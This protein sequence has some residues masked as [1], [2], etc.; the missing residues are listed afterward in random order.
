MPLVKEYCA[1]HQLPYMVDDYFTGW[2][3]GI[4]Q[5][6]RIARLVANRIEKENS[7]M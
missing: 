5:F 2:K 1:R 6:A 7:S 4:D 3:L